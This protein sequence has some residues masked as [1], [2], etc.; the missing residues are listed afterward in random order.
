MLKAV[1]FDLDDTLCNTSEIIDEALIATFEGHL[2]HFPEKKVEKLLAINHQAFKE[3]FLNPNIPVPSATILIWFRIFELANAKPQLKTIFTIIEQIRQEVRK[4]IKLLPGAR[5]IVD[6]LIY[7]HIKIGILSNGVF[8][9]Q[10]EKL[11][12]LNLDSKIEY[13]VTPDICLADKPNKKA[14][15]YI[16]EK[17]ETD[18]VDTIMFGDTPNIDIFGAK[19]VGMKAI[20][21]KSAHNKL[22]TSQK[23]KA[24]FECSNL[25]EAK[26]YLEK[27][28]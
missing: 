12:I 24:D 6:Y 2:V 16:L 22:L 10:A 17:L 19:N 9:E 3:V 5:E 14:F 7:K 13:L 25:F 28:L 21:L 8:L 1:I 11:I 27:L 23:T 15:Q 18:P 26:E 20:L 4:R